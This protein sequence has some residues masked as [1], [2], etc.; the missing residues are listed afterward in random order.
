MFAQ[1]SLPKKTRRPAARGNRSLHILEQHLLLCGMVQKGVDNALVE[2]LDELASKKNLETVSTE[3]LGNMSTLAAFQAQLD[4]A[5]APMYVN[6]F[7]N[8]YTADKQN[9]CK[10]KAKR[11]GIT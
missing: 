1:T 10:T 8:G 4:I 3:A 7:S 9:K 11:M 5:E 2:L 6:Q